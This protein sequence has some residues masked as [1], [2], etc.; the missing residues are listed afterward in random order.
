[1]FRPRLCAVALCLVAALLS[2][3]AHSATH[4]DR[5][6]PSSRYSDPAL[7]GAPAVGG[8]PAVHGAHA[9]G[10]PAVHGAPASDQLEC[11]TY[12]GNQVES[13]FQHA[14]YEKKKRR[15]QA[16]GVSSPAL[17]HFIYE[18][19]WVVED[20]GTLLDAGNN[21]FDTDFATFRFTPN[22]SGY[23]VSEIAFAFDAAVGTN[24]G[25]GDD[26]NTTQSLQFAFTLYGVQWNDVHINSNGIVSFGADVN[27]TGVFDPNDFLGPTP[28]VAGYFIDL[29]P[30][31]GGAV[32]YK[33][34]ATKAT[35]SWV[36]VPEFGTFNNNT[37]Q[38]VLHNNGNIDV[39]FNGVQPT[40]SNGIAIVLG[41]NPGGAPPLQ[42]ISF[43]DDLPFSGQAGAAIF[44][45]YLNISN[46]R[47]NEVA[48]MQA[49]YQNFPDDFFQI[50]FFTN[51]TQ[52][53]AG[54]ANE[55]NI[56]N[57]ATGIGLALFDNSQ[58]Y[59]SNGILESRCNMNQLA[60]WP[61]DPSQRFRGTSQQSFLTIMA[62][63]AGHRWGAFV[64]F[65]R[66]GGA[67]NFLLGRSDA[68]WNYYLDIEHSGLEGGEWG[69]VAPGQY[70]CP[71]FVDEFAQLDE[72]LF[73]LR[74]AEEVA[75]LFYVSSPSNN[76]TAARSQPPPP[77][78]AFA[79]GTP[80]TVT[81]EDIIAASGPR[82][83]TVADEDKDLRQ[84]FILIHRTG[85]TPTQAEL[86]KVAGFRAAWEP[87]FEQSC[88]GRLTCNTSITQT[89]AVGSIEGVV[90]DAVTQMPLDEFE[91]L[92]TE[93]VYSQAVPG[94]GRYF[95]RYM[96]DANSAATENVTLAAVAPGYDTKF[97]NATVNFGQDRTI[98]IAMEPVVPTFITDFSARPVDARIE[99][100][101]DIIS[102][103]ELRGFRIYR[104]E[105]NA[106]ASALND[107]A[108]LATSTTRHS[109]GDVT[110]GRTYAYTL[111]VVF[112]DGSE[113][114]SQTAIARANPLTLALA[115]NHPN[116]FNPTTTISFVLA[117]RG[118]VE[119]SVFDVK[120]KRV[121]TLASATLPAGAG[122]VTWDGR[123]DGG[124]PVGSGIYFYRL[125][126]AGRQLTRKMLLLK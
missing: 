26:T 114:R 103:D 27:P 96:A 66:G 41:I 21:P 70:R 102:D 74:T 30:S 79:F 111:A 20:D 98:D 84:A 75:P 125:T 47:V 87:Y 116:P 86:D 85:T 39:T 92:S 97:V 101:W 112:E 52:T 80:V 49:F 18:D 72:Y 121:R 82:T 94:G 38:V 76:G 32:Y 83:P 107:G 95:F 81:I 6:F 109:D 16:Q 42:E 51:F 73:G 4:P 122:Q 108:L 58:L 119:L 117:E 5:Y 88:D 113:M 12:K 14:R 8:A 104:S 60:V 46:P 64:F 65:D 90:R 93:R 100:A 106:P 29:D 35:V 33:S 115:Q 67:S 44:E 17:N 22:G 54:F 120:G 36:G 55:L 34:E 71:S 31:S 68:H 59:G 9:G 53:M 11:G 43:S 123:D 1:M 13:L 37:A 10:V 105:N 57:S 15:L 45:S 77:R 28:K 63:E 23:D 69:E 24:L 3:S 56:E 25:L 7:M 99:L 91:I 48:L 61:T 62:Q 19:V 2:S 50:V 89:F 110:P 118:L 78:N 126:S 40:S 124:T